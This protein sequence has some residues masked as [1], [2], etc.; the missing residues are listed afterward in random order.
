MAPRKSRSRAARERPTLQ[1]PRSSTRSNRYPNQGQLQ[2]ERRS[3][4]A[5]V[6]VR[7][8]QILTDRIDQTIDALNQVRLSVHRLG[9]SGFHL[10]QMNP[11][12]FMCQS[13]Q[14]YWMQQ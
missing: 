5:K 7:K 10:K 14:G 13:D 12:D 4:K 1:S 8:L 9:H 6:D 2:R 11:L 3:M